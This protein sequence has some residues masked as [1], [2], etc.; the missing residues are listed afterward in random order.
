MASKSKAARFL[1]VR[2]YPHEG[3]VL[4]GRRGR[5]LVID[6]ETGTV[7]GGHNHP[8]HGALNGMEPQAGLSAKTVNELAAA[9]AS[10][11]TPFV[12]A[13]DA[14]TAYVNTSDGLLPA[15]GLRH[16]EPVKDDFTDE[17]EVAVRRREKK[18]EYLAKKAEREAA[19]ASQSDDAWP[20]TS[21]SR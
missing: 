13:D 6:T 2:A 14:L 17:R 8:S 20:G 3:D 12:Y 16:T 5:R 21:R 18:A 7:L 11:R 1:A 10:S 9:L 19:K 4:T 15:E